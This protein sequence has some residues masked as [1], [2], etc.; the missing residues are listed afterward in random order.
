MIGWMLGTRLT[1]REIANMKKQVCPMP[2]R[3]VDKGTAGLLEI[4]FV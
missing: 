2:L 4:A 1:S 3:Y